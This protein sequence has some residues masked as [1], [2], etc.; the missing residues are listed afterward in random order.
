M[1]LPDPKPQVRLARNASLN[2]AGQAVPILVALATMPVVVRGLGPAQFGVVA[3]AWTVVGYVAVFDLGFGRATT[4]RVSEAHWAGDWG[5]IRRVAGT[6]AAAQLALGLL[7]G[8]AVWLAAP[9]LG[10]LLL[11]AGGAGVR[12]AVPDAGVVIGTLALAV[13]AVLVSNAYRA[14]LEGLQR[15]DLVNAA[16]APLSATM[17]LIPFAGVLAGWRLETII[18]GLALTRLLGAGTFLLLFSWAAP[19]ATGTRAA[20]SAVGPRGR[21]DELRDLL[22]FGGWVGVSNTVI[23][24]S[25]YLE[26]FLVSAILGPAALAFYAAPHELIWKLQL[27]PA[28]IAGVLFPALSGLFGA[29]DRAEVLRRSGQGLRLITLLVGPAAALLILVA[30]PLLSVWLGGEYGAASSGVLR[31]LALA[32]ALNAVIFVPFVVL[33]GAGSPGTIA[34]YHLAELPVF[35]LGLWWLVSAYGIHGAAAAAAARMLVMLVVLSAGALRHGGFALGDVLTP[36]TRRCLFATAALLA[37]AYALVSVLQSPWAVAG[38]GSGLLGIYG[39]A[40]W[41]A[42]LEDADRATV[43]A[44]LRRAGRHLRRG[45]I[46]QPGG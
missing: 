9:W 12:E 42:F 34:R 28:A 41:S 33:E 29:G 26:R 40:A 13:P 18:G 7:T 11:S 31:L 4:K 39:L 30:E 25:F 1:T 32:V 38:A 15:F 43:S 2:L 37:G 27:V 45:V 14:A 22:R 35:G 10:R 20:G 21:L 46:P 24:F 3:F 23:P 36:A 6:A 8:G 5:R 19:A 17:F 44:W 16:R